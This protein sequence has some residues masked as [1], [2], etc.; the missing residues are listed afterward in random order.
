MLNYYHAQIVAYNG[1]F[2]AVVLSRFKFNPIVDLMLSVWN[3]DVMYMSMLWLSRSRAL[4]L[5]KCYE[6]VIGYP[7][8]KEFHISI[9][10]CEATRDIFFKILECKPPASAPPLPTAGEDENVN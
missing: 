7:F 2:D 1:A 3:Y 6:A 5:G 8:S 10:D 9:N 4:T